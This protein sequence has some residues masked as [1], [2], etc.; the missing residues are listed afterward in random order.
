M[1]LSN[2][3]SNA[4]KYSADHTFIYVDVA[5]RS[6]SIVL[7][8]EDR[9]IGIPQETQQQLFKEFHRATNV[10][11]VPGTGLGL[12]I[13]KQCVDLHQGTIIVESAVDVGSTF[14]INLP[15]PPQP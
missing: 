15:S 4:I 8:V 7:Q 5:C 9:G 1:I 12:S 14:I 2:L 6:D 10:G 13:V 11:S 3:V